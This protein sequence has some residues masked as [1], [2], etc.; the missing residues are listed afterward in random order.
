DC[1][2]Q[3]PMAGNRHNVDKIIFITFMVRLFLSDIYIIMYSNK[4]NI[5]FLIKQDALIF[6]STDFHQ[7]LYSII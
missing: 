1:C 2:A 6:S 3:S 7:S 4:C 5:V